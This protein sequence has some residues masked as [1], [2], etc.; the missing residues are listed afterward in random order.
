LK[1]IMLER[2][3][4]REYYISFNS[5]QRWTEQMKDEERGKGNKK[6]LKMQSETEKEEKEGERGTD[7]QKKGNTRRTKKN[8]NSRIFFSCLTCL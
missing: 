5:R 6:R 4:K 1:L 2:E 3:R 8:Y 7:R